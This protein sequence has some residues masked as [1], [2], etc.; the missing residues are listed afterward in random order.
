MKKAYILSAL[1]IIFSGSEDM[2][3]SKFSKNSRRFS[4]LRD[5]SANLE[6]LH[7]LIKEVCEKNL[8]FLVKIVPEIIRLYLPN[9]Q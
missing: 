8:L 5:R 4:Q 9:I 1:D 6:S 2:T 3:A 7:S